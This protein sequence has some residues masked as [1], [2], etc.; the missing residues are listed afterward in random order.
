MPQGLAGG[1][2]KVTVLTTSFVWLTS[3]EW[4][5]AHS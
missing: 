5:H 1:T 4:A 2:L 3:V